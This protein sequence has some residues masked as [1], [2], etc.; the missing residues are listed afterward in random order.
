MGTLPLEVDVLFELEQERKFTEIRSKK[1]MDVVFMIICLLI[2][3]AYAFDCR[4]E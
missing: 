1:N 2:L 4:S 3:I